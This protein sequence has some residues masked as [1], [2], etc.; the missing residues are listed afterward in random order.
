MDKNKRIITCEPMIVIS[1]K[2]RTIDGMMS[3]LVEGEIKLN[4]E[5]ERLVGRKGGSIVLMFNVK[6]IDVIYP[7]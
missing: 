6:D 7:M 2:E 4:I 5:G 1:L 3:I